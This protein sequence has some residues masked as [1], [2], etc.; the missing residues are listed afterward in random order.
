MA[1]PSRLFVNVDPF[2]TRVAL[3]EEG[4]VTEFHIE[5]AVERSI[6]NAVYAGKVQRVLPGMQACFIDIG[7]DRAAFLQLGDAMKFL[8]EMI[9]ETGGDEG[10]KARAHRSIRDI[11]REGQEVLVQV[12]KAPIST[13]GARVTPNIA[14]PGR[15]LVYLPQVSHIGIS[16]RIEDQAERQRLRGIVQGHRDGDEGG[17][18]CRTASAGR[19]REAIESEMDGLRSEWEV[20]QKARGSGAAPILL[21]QDHDLV[22]RAFRDLFSGAVD[23]V[24]IDDAE[25]Y[26]RLS[27]Y[28]RR[29]MPEATAAIDLYQGDEPIFD[30]YGIEEEL[31]RAL[32]RRV[33]LPS[34]GSLVIDQAEALTAIDVNTGKFTGK[35]NFEETI[36]RNNLEAVAEAAY[37]LRF[38]NIG[39][40]IIID[41]IDM[42]STQNRDQVYRALLDALRH[43]KARTSV[44]RISELG[45]V[46]MTRKRTRESLGRTLHEPCWYC[47]GTGAVRSKRTV[48][49]EILREVRREAGGRKG[50]SWVLLVHPAVRDALRG[51][52]KSYLERTTGALGLNLRIEAVPEYHIEAFTIRKG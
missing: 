4:K 47:D 3:S 13:K 25:A 27:D 50:G 35:R 41:F 5:R 16:R 9:A 19:P 20:I 36:L 14:L 26:R 39:G 32:Q 7:L 46:E 34:G 10:S 49:Y 30:A 42:E 28:A 51:P 18:I 44:I 40:L 45:L 33:P 15:T 48:C 29:Y 22:I 1:R 37:Q 31:K 8:D 2:E 24:V 11:L 23:R 21:R 12:S 43:D 17:F 38:R 6:E 52:E